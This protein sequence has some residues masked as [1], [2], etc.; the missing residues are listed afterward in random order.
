MPA[1]LGDLIFHV[2]D[3]AINLLQ[4]SL[5]DN[6]HLDT[7]FDRRNWAAPD[8]IIRISDRR[9]VGHDLAE[10]PVSSPCFD[11]DAAI[12]HVQNRQAVI[13]SVEIFL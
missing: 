1:E 3:Y 8:G 4:H 9:D 13:H 10:T 11:P 5:M 7:D 2:G 12:L 6:L